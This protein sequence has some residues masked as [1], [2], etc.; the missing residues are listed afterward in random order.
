MTSSVRPSPTEP[1]WKK[2]ARLGL[3][4]F[5]VVAIAAGMGYSEVRSQVGE[6]LI[7]VGEN[8]MRYGDAAHQDAPRRIVLNGQTLWLS[9]GVADRP[10]RDVLDHFQSVCDA[11]DAGLVEQLDALAE[12]ALP[13]DRE[14][15]ARPSVRDENERAGYVGCLDL[16]EASV[17]ATEILARLRTYGRSHDLADIGDARYVYAAELSGDPSR[18][19]FVTAWTDGSLR[20]DLLFPEQGD[21]DGRDPAY[22]PRPP[23]A[24]RVLSAYEDGLPQEATVFLGSSL[25]EDAL[26]RFYRRELPEQGWTLLEA[27]EADPHVGEGII[28]LVAERDQRMVMLALSSDA[29]GRGRATVLTAR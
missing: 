21:A 27:P 8:L 22:V 20:F 7:G 16:G 18:S 13:T 19:H 4:A 24:R 1:L 14:H 5:C 23:G 10:F 29:E 25:D 3:F 2:A 6:Q 12:R 17:P 9:T 11:H 28:S 26:L 15:G